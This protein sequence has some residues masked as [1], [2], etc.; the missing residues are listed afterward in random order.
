MALMAHDEIVARRRVPS[1]Q[2]DK[3]VADGHAYVSATGRL[4]LRTMVLAGCPWHAMLELLLPVVEAPSV[5]D[6]D[7]SCFALASFLLPSPRG[8][9]ISC[10]FGCHSRLAQV[11]K[12]MDLTT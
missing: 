5:P 7:C 9:L 10:C 4:G 8:M 6:L 2:V 12:L 11:R 1:E 3:L